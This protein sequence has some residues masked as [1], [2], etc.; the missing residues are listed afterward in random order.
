[1]RVQFARWGN[2]VALRIP[3]GALR[4]LGAAEGTPADLRV[5]AGRLV[6]IPVVDRPRYALDDRL[7]GITDENRHD[8]G[9]A[10]SPRGPELL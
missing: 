10:D 4:E 1:M 2:S 6:V 8:D 3:S 5:E 7:A 9:L